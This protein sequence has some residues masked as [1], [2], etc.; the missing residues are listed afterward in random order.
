MVQQI[1]RPPTLT[2]A[3]TNAIRDAILQ[4]DLQPGQ[5]LR[6]VELSTSLNVA[7]STMREALHWLQETMCRP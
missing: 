4:G 1:I 7:R 5:P 3:T 2:A 6:E